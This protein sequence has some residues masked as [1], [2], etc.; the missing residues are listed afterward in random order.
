MMMIIIIMLTSSSWWWNYVAIFQL[1]CVHVYC[2]AIKLTC[3][4]A[5]IAQWVEL[6]SLGRGLTDLVLFCCY[7]FTLIT[8]QVSTAEGGYEIGKLWKHWSGDPRH[9]AKEYD[10][11]LNCKYAKFHQ[12]RLTRSLV[13][14]KRPCDCCIILKSGSYTK[15][16]SADRPISIKSR[17]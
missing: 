1:F 4:N 6:F 5:V 13:I 15:A 11:G 7:L 16:N 2:C 10:F 14:A 8:C 9:M 17:S 3:F 12:S